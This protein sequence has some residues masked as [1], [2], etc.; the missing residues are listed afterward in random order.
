MSSFVDELELRISSVHRRRSKVG[1]STHDDPAAVAVVRGK[2]RKAECDPL[3]LGIVEQGQRNW[4]KN[5]KLRALIKAVECLLGRPRHCKDTSEDAQV[6][7]PRS[8]PA[9]AFGLQALNVLFQAL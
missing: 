2:H 6:H 4:C 7:S 1:C 3:V 8:Y 9:S 5:R